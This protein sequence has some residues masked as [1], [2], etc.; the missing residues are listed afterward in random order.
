MFCYN[1]IKALRDEKKW[2]LGDI[3]FELAKKN[4][5]YTRQTILNWETG[6]T[7]PNA[8]AIACLADVF[9][10]EVGDFFTE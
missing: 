7:E 10:V 8:S 4:H 1:K 5:R 9:G 3:V 2:T 6:S